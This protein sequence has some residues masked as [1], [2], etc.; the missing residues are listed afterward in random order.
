[1]YLH[2]WSTNKGYVHNTTYQCPLL[3]RC[4]CPCVAK[5][6]ES[7][8]QFILYIQKEYTAADHNDDNSR[9]FSVDKQDSVL[10]LRLKDC[11]YEDAGVKLQ[12]RLCH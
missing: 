11:S 2:S 6:E 3:E 7:P 4:G 12:D 5:I 8:E 10:E 9:Y 1:M